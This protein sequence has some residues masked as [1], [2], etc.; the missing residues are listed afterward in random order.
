MPPVCDRSLGIDVPREATPWSRRA[1]W[2]ERIALCLSL[3]YLCVHTLPQAWRTLNTDFPNYYMAARLAHEGYDTSRMYEWSWIERE[4]DHRA[5]DI[6]VIGLLPITPFSTLMVW[7]L[8]G[9]APL[10]AKH[11][12]ILV[13]LALLVPVGWMLRW[14]TGRHYRQIALAFTLCFPLYRNLLFGQFYVLLLF[15]IVAGCWSYL[16][17]F[18]AL[19]GALIALAAAC[20]IFPALLF[21]FF[22]RRRDWRALA[23]GA[24]TAIA[25]AAISV[26]VFGW[27]VH[28]TYLREIL[29]WALRGGGLEPYIPGASISSVL[30]YLFLSEPQWNPHPWHYSPLSYALLMCGLQMLALAPAILLLR[31]KEADRGRTLLEWSALLTA[32][33][34]DLRADAASYNFVL[35]VFPFCVL[36]AVLFQRKQYR[37]LTALVIAYLGIGFPLP[38]AQRVVGPAILLYVPRLPL[39]FALLLGIYVLLWREDRGEG[40]SWDWTRYGLAAALAASLILNAVSTFRLERAVREEYK[41]RLPLQMQGFLNSSPQSTGAGVRYSAFTL[42]GYRLVTEG[43]GSVRF[44][45]PSVA[46]FDDLSFASGHGHTWVERAS[47]PRSQ[48]VDLQQ[49]SLPVIDDGREPRLSADG[50]SLGFLRDDHGRGQLMVRRSLESNANRDV[51]LTPSRLNIYEASFVSEDE[52]AFSAVADGLPP[53]VYLTDATHKNSPIGLGESR[54]PAISPDGRWMAYSHLEQGMWNLWLRDQGTGV[55]RRIGNV[56]CNQVQA[57]WEA[58]SKTIVYGTDC[59]RSVWFTAVARRRVIP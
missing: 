22:L 31:G 51:A 26:A 25:A 20:K 18:H 38:I 11:I 47:S 4:K 54:Y 29:P 49:P 17:G 5:I 57:S 3:L 8:T 16:R 21:V 50:Q 7:P 13:N 40:I 55:T 19:A 58:D 27:N 15:L 34:A 10:T 14:M 52:Y 32:S 30:H 46:P 59:G 9:L 23:G 37:W 28:R 39:T 2:C 45:P 35:L 42:T 6:R 48:I 24:V 12:W 56:P 33:L 41:F 36:A 53:E 44:D 1:V 43:Q